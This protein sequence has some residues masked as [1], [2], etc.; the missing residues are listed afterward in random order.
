MS[1][2]R[3][4]KVYLRLPHFPE[5]RCDSND[6]IPVREGLRPGCLQELVRL[7]VVTHDLDTLNC[8]KRSDREPENAK[9]FK[10]F[11]AAAPSLLGGAAAL[12]LLPFA[13]QHENPSE[14]SPKLEPQNAGAGAGS[15]LQMLVG[16]RSAATFLTGLGIS[17]RR[18]IG[19]PQ[20][21]RDR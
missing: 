15:M 21:P 19:Y 10:V 14:S 3:W 11:I 17:R 20:E 4:V 12:S 2:V 9:T 16:A 8:S 18:T 7:Y 1:S 6:R 5:R 13:R